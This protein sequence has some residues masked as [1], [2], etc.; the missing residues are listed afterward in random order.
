ML[1]DEG[2]FV[3]VFRGNWDLPVSGFEVSCSEIV[4]S[5]EFVQGLVKRGNWIV[6]PG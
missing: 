2:R 4:G 6:V 3:A 5:G 1:R